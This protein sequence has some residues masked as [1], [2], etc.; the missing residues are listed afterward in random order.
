[1]ARA[2]IMSWDL[3]RFERGSA[4]PFFE[5]VLAS[6]LRT[7]AKA[8]L[9]PS[10]IDGIITIQ[11]NFAGP[12]FNV[13]IAEVLG[14]HPTYSV[15]ITNYGASP[16]S[17]LWHAKMAI[18]SKLATRILIV[19]GDLTYQ[20][21]RR[22]SQR[23]PSPISILDEFE[24]PYG[25]HMANSDYAMIAELH[26]KLYGTTDE[27]RAKVVVDQRVSAL[28]NERALFRD[29]IKIDDVTSSRIVSSPLHLLECVATASG[30]S[31]LLV[32]D[33]ANADEIATG[34]P[35]SIEGFGYHQSGFTLA[36]AQLLRNGLVSGIALAGKNALE[37]A[38][39][40]IGEVDIF[41]IY[42]CYPIAVMIALEDLGVV[43]K[44]EVGPW[45]LETNLTR[46]GRYPVN[47]SGGQLSCGQIGDAGGMVNL[48]EVV[49]RLATKSKKASGGDFEVGLVTSNGGPAMSCES[50]VIL[51]VAN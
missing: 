37:M 29:P 36:N 49:E 15:D 35:I 8:N 43:P 31:S 34:V 24:L 6:L 40:S 42:D 28:T 45:V 14:I 48:I 16:A 50:V 27:M 7:L 11:S 9:S 39:V 46:S 26:R 2:A 21:M 12:A 44:G 17:A 41:G 10:A 20:E 5:M 22:Q 3:S 18:E 1:M 47:T 51:K 19:G 25:S 38:K 33:V 4:P 32:T 23:R 13:T 30:A